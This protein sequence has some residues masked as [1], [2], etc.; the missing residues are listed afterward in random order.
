MPVIFYLKQENIL[1]IFS[2]LGQIRDVVF[3]YSK[4]LFV[5]PFATQPKKL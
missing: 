1:T 4:I 2:Y 5:K 3:F